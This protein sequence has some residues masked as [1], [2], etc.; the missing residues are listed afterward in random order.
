MEST[1]KQWFNEWSNEYD[2]TL[3]KLQRHHDLL[4][5]VV[6]LSE[7]SDG[8]SVLDIGCG[9]GL[10]SLKFLGAADCRVSGIDLS[11]EML[12]IWKEKI[13]KF[14]L[15]DRVQCSVGNADSL[16][17]ENE[18]FD[19]VASTVTLHHIR[20]KQPMI[21]DIHRI[22]KHGGR[23]LIGDLDV[24]TSGALTDADRLRH[25]MDYLKEELTLALQDGGVEAL[26]R[27]YDNGKKHLLNDGEYCVNFDHWS[28]L[29]STAG[30]RVEKVVPVPSF[31]WM[32]VLYA[33]KK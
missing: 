9:T 17:F 31:P 2:T 1:T 21:N 24:E 14:D 3:G 15:H 18:S 5:L 33:V 29:C 11:E 30:F 19:V 26:G 28:R 27:M 22:L 25:I 12:A 4:D 8:E 7:V 13:E 32:K 20:D 16:T 23:F 6:R 10:L